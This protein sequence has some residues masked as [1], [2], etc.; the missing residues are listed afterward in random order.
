MALIIN[1]VG[2]VFML[3]SV[4]LFGLKGMT[5][6][7]GIAV[8]ASCVFLAF[9]N[10]DKFTKFK[11]AGFE[12]ELREAVSEANATINE[13]KE[14]AK[15]LI[16]TNFEILAQANRMQGSNFEKTH[17]LFDQ[18]QSLQVKFQLEDT[19]IEKSK[20]SYIVIHAWD[21]VYEILDDVQRVELNENYQRLKDTIG[22]IN[23]ETMPDIDAFLTQ[24]ETLNLSKKDEFKLEKLREYK[25]KYKL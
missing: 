24:V 22:Q 1:I 2:F 7:M 15:P 20:N 12:A 8:A 18:L 5:A 9:A 16:R 13:L 23:F 25:L 17:D 21:M 3:V 6:E 4:F 11:G 10:L 14:L 19:E